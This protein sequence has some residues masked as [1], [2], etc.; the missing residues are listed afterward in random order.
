M[1][2]HHNKIFNSQLLVEVG[3]SGN[4]SKDEVGQI[5]SQ[6]GG[7][8]MLRW[9]VHRG[10]QLSTQLIITDLQTSRGLQIS[11][12]EKSEL[13][14]L[15]FHGQAAESKHYITERNAKCRMQESKTCC[16]LSLEQ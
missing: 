2:F 3:M 16:Q 8:W 15:G 5:K 11:V 4:N 9:V 12:E 14:R 13:C 1:K 6:N 10:P 7:Q